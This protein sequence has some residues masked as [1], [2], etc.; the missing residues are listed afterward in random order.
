MLIL[1]S[2]VTDGDDRNEPFDTNVDPVFPLFDVVND[3]NDT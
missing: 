3:S 2:D 1:S